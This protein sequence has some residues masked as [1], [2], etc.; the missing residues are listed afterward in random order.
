MSFSKAHA[1]AFAPATIGNVGI[2]FDIL[3]MAIAGVGDTVQLSIRADD[4]ILIQKIEGL[5]SDLPLKAEDNTAGAALLALQRGEKLKKGFD[6]II[7]KGIPLGSGMGGSAASAVAAVVAANALLKKKLSFTKQFHYALE[8][9]KIA[10][11][12][13]HPDN[14]APCL[15]GGLTLASLG[16]LNPVEALP[17]PKNLGWVLVHPDV[18]VETK[19]ARG[20]LQKTVALEN[21]VEQ[22]A[23]L[24]SFIAGLYKK[25][26]QMIRQGLKDILIEP[27]RAALIPAFAEIKTIALRKKGVLGFSIS[28]SGPSVFAWTETKAQAASLGKLMQAQFLQNGVTSQVYVGQGAAPGARVLPAPGRLKK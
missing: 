2:G 9:E 24:A 6:V 22:S 4:K 21:Y 3:G 7:Q 8:G 5:V 27:Q 20:L 12:A 25:D 14:V 16:F 28:G 10:S 26:L 1:T 15:K 11:G 18:K 13:A 23:H 19:Q 17:L